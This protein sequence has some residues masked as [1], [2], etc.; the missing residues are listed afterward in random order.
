MDDVKE[1]LIILPSLMTLLSIALPYGEQNYDDQTLKS[2]IMDV[3]ALYG[4]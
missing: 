3:L 2:F 1:Q 4:N